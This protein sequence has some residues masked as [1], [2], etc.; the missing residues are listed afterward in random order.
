[1]AHPSE[2]WRLYFSIATGLWEAHGLWHGLLTT[3]PVVPL[4]RPGGQIFGEMKTLYQNHYH[5]PGTALPG[6]RSI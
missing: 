5:L 6:T 3:L 4:S 1:M 2:L